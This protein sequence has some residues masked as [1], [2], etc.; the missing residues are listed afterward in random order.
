MRDSDSDSSIE[1]IVPVAKRRKIIGVQAN[2]WHSDSTI[3][4]KDFEFDKEETKEEMQ[5]AIPPSGNKTASR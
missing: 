2:N 3:S 1:T 4:E 5:T